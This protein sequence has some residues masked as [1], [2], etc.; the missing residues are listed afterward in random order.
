MKRL[1]K[2]FHIFIFFQMAYA[3]VDFVGRK[4]IEV[5]PC[6]WISGST[7]MWPKVPLDKLKTMVKKNS[8]CSSSLPWQRYEVQVKGLF[9]KWIHALAV[10]TSLF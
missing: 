5:V 9:G 10:K 4:E 6:S 1:I 3:I 7:C 2:G 8:P